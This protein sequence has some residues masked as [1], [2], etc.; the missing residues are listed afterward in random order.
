MIFINLIND[1]AFVLAAMAKACFMVH[2][3]CLFMK[4]HLLALVE[5][6]C[7]DLVHCAFLH[8]LS[9]FCQYLLRSIFEVDKIG[10]FWPIPIYQ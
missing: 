10:P 4:L 2:P 6:N 8:K 5:N 1:D 3:V 7:L 9:A